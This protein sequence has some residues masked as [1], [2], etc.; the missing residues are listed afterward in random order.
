MNAATVRVEADRFLAAD[1]IIRSVCQQLMRGGTLTPQDG[2][3]L[4]SLLTTA[5]G[6]LA[7][8]RDRAMEAAMAG[9]GGQ[10]G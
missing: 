7:P 10:E 4:A 9:D 3:L 2:A 1:D 5:R 6:L 8:A